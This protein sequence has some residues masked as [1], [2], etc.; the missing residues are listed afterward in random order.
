MCSPY[1]TK[2][3]RYP[4]RWGAN[5]KS[6]VAKGHKNR[7]VSTVYG[8]V[9]IL[10]VNRGQGWP[11]PSSSGRCL[12]LNYQLF[13]RISQMKKQTWGAWEMTLTSTSRRSHWAALKQ[14]LFATGGRDWKGDFQ[15]KQPRHRPPTDNCWQVAV[16]QVPN[17]NDTQVR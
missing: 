2:R 5:W 14:P 6:R 15:T 16:L 12:C 3:D 13:K 4:K 9:V 17:W 11:F 10:R 1:M 8:D 7:D